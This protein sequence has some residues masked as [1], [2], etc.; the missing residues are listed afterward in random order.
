MRWKSY[1]AI[2][3]IS[4][5]AISCPTLILL[6]CLF[7]RSQST[8]GLVRGVV[9]D[10]DNRVIPSARI[11]FLNLETG[12]RRELLTSSDGRFWLNGLPTGRYEAR[13]ELEGFTSDVRS[14]VVVTVAEEVVVNFKLKVRPLSEEIL[15]ADDGSLVE[16]GTSAL[17]TVV[18]GQKIRDL[19]LNGRDLG[20]LILLQPG[21]VNSRSSVQSANT[22]RG[23][24][25]SAAGAR[26]NQNLFTIDGTTINDALNNTPGSAQG[27]L[28]GVETVKEFR[29]LTTNFG[30]EYGRAAGGVFLGVTK[31]G[32]NAFHGSLFEFLRNDVFDARNFFDQSKPE[33]RRNQFGLSAGGPLVRNRTF[34][35]GSYEGLRE[36]KGV[37][38]VSLVPD[39][40]ARE[41]S[42]PGQPAISVDPRSQ[43]ILDLFPYPN[44]ENLGDGTASFIGT[45]KRVS[46]G[47]FFTIKMDHNFSSSDA[48][49]VRYLFDDSEQLLP[50]NFPE[51]PNFAVNRKQVVTIEERKI[52]SNRVVNEARFG[53]NRSTPAEQVPQTSRDLSLISGQDLGEINVAGLTEIGTDRTN[54]KG[55]FLNNV[56]AGDTL[57]IARGRNNLKLGGSFDRFQYNGSS[58]S[59]TRGLLRF[60]S[61]ADLLRFRVRDLEG[62]TPDSDFVRGYRQNLSGIFVQDEFKVT[63]RLTLNGG[64][65][66]EWVSTPTEVNGK[67][68]NLRNVLD[69]TVTVGRPYFQ[70]THHTFAPRV[71]FALDVLG[72]GRTVIRSGFGVYFD[73]PLFHIFRSPAFRSLPFVNRGRL[74]SVTSLPVDPSQFKGIESATEALQFQLQPSY[75]MRYHLNLQ[76][77]VSGMVLSLSYLGSRG[78]NL[79]GGS[80]T[81]IAYPQVQPDGREFFAEGSPR[82]NPN[83]AQVRTILQ[84]FGSSYN[85]LTAGMTRYFHNDLQFQFAYTYGKSIDDATG[86]SRLDYSNGQARSFD[87]YN[88]RLNR[89]LSD[90]D[91][92]HTVTANA[93]YN[94]PLGKNLTGFSKQLVNGWQLNLIVMLN[95][96][97]PFTPLV[98]GDPD[99]DGTDENVARPN[100][101]Q[102]ASLV[103]TGGRTPDLW[104]NP[105][106]FAPPDVGFRGTAGRNIITGPN[107]RSVDFSL[108]KSFPIDEKRRLEF[109]V[110]AFNLFN[111][112]NF[113]LPSNSEDGELAYNYFP[114]ASGSPARFVQ[115]P[116]I[117]RIFSTVGDSREFQFA[118]KFV[119]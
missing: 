55:F 110:E 41:G 19:P 97:V 65:R 93:S 9:S 111:R 61:V 62:A 72:D 3:L 77:E 15:V 99:R 2:K 51:F 22:G 87:P 11:V 8:S 47:D 34:W 31:S 56:Q 114:A 13:A 84:G 36:N 29:V 14:E 48:I 98:D 16:T 50:R 25:F 74:T 78:I 86:T 70:P 105:Q 85:A 91:I 94:V 53:F 52:L 75:S 112:A 43:P 45:T 119:F 28:L 73:Q 64:V 79:V 59:R 107:Y 100:W 67:E 63:N 4:R 106:A 30:A 17:S 117:G 23:I 81:N 49:S 5:V 66:H 39:E 54:P 76:Q 92:R 116:S 113:D 104:F 21:I 96:G 27:L 109:R 35:F 60:R 40:N 20:Q 108:I 68:A 24:R 12:Q 33:F 7:A 32:S 95:S 80:D 38:K 101:L 115:A 42:L 103:Q 82:R 44:G 10:P 18:V 69:K 88:R 102:G 83:F 90:F 1:R 71:G 46:N 37:T 118:L 57:F 58:E 26:P 89:A 6:F